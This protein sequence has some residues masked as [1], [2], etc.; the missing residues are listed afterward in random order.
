[1]VVASHPFGDLLRVSQFIVRGIIE[2]N[3]AG[4]NGPVESFRHVRDHRSR[5]HTAAQ[6]C[7]QRHIA[8][9]AN[10]Y[11]FAKNTIQFL[12]KFAFGT[13]IRWK[14]GHIPVFSH[15]RRFRRTDEDVSGRQ[16]LNALED[17]HR[18]GHVEKAQ[19]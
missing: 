8:S 2:A 14:A 15:R 19:I 3:R 16:F 18:A 12:Q 5:V 6:E 11:G 10:L 17:R 9:E 1:M 7:S 13:R 4:D